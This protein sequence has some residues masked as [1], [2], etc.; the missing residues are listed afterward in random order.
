MK[1]YEKLKTIQQQNKGKIILIRNGVF[2]IA[3]GKDAVLMHQILNLKTICFKENIC[4]C[5]IPVKNITKKIPL[6][7][8]TGYSYIIYDYNKETKEYKQIYEIKGKYIEEKNTNINCE[9]CTNKNNK[10][11]NTQD[12]IDELENLNKKGIINIWKKTAYY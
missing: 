3:V 11:K 8:E 10:T 1:F 12:Y 9:I 4:K 6:L 5:A 7:I 2:F